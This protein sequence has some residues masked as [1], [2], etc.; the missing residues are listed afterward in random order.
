MNQIQ[1]VFELFNRIIH[2]I[3]FLYSPCPELKP[4]LNPY[5]TIP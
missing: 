4:P 3:F 1:N 5:K 2:S